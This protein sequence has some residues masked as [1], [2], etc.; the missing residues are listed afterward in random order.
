MLLA[1]NCIEVDC[2]DPARCCDFEIGDKRMH[3]EIPQ[4]VNDLG[5]DA[6]EFIGSVDR[7]VRYKVY[8][9]T[10]YKYHKYRKRK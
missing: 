8:T 4:L 9:D 6:I 5:S 7:E 3:F 2:E 1:I 10:S